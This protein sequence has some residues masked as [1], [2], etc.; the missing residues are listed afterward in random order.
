MRYPFDS[1]RRQ[2]LQTAAIAAS[3]LSLSA[4]ATEPQSLPQGKPRVGCLSWCFHS[5][6][7][8]ADP[9]P[10]LDI[11]GELGVPIL[12]HAS[13]SHYFLEDQPRMSD[14]GHLAELARR[15]PEAMLICAHICGEG[16]H[17]H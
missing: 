7:P 14:G 15:Y 13:H 17:D 9:E 11:I 6:S 3:G 4:N 8:A 2:F 16:N 5:L 10:A 1:N 12:Q